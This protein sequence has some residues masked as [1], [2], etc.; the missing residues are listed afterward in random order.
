MLVLQYVTLNCVLLPVAN[1]LVMFLGNNFLNFLFFKQT[2]FLLSSNV[3]K[4]S[5]NK[6]SSKVVYLV[7]DSFC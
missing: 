5:F 7:Y 1:S 3:E 6:A 4:F 2:S